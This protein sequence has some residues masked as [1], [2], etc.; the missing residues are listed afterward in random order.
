MKIKIPNIFTTFLLF[1]LIAGVVFFSYHVLMQSGFLGKQSPDA[2][3]KVVDLNQL[4]INSQPG[5][6]ISSYLQQYEKIM[7]DA[8]GEL[9]AQ[10][11]GASPAQVQGLESDQR[12]LLTQKAL[13]K[14]KCQSILLNSV[15]QAVENDSNM[16]LLTKNTVI[17]SPLAADITEEV[18]RQ[19]LTAAPEIPELPEVTVKKI[20]PQQ[21]LKPSPAIQPEK[22]TLKGKNK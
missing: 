10:K 14:E 8:I 17:T 15:R 1:C 4:M 9:E 7:D 2:V 18:T 5:K 6:K 13:E 12:Y 21:T 19:L 22:G 11:S 16:I 20:Q 3:V